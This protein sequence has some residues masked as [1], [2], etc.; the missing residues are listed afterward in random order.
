MFRNNPIIFFQTFSSEQQ[1]LIGYERIQGMLGEKL[2]KHFNQCVVDQKFDSDNLRYDSDKN[3]IGKIPTL[4]SLIIILHHI[5][6]LNEKLLLQ[7]ISKIDYLT[8]IK[9]S[10]YSL[11][12]TNALLSDLNA[13]DN[14]T[15]LLAF[16]LN[17][18]ELENTLFQLQYRLKDEKWQKESFYATSWQRCYE[19]ALA[20][21][22][23]G[24]NCYH[25]LED[26][27]V[28]KLLIGD[29][30]KENLARLA[31][32]ADLIIKEEPAFFAQYGG[33]KRAST[34]QEDFD[35]VMK[36]YD[37]RVDKAAIPKA[38]SMLFKAVSDSKSSSDDKKAVPSK[39]STATAMIP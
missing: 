31:K 29:K 35:R 20:F 32:H 5:G 38:A 34:S 6:L 33:I 24:Y 18:R 39:K 1:L 27:F 26:L 14:V 12:K 13:E 8:E 19:F 9:D 15:R 16:T 37:A 3:I 28:A 23:I 11:F 30:G 21:P 7:F 10:L 4:M 25:I 17:Y 22:S 36:D 2:I